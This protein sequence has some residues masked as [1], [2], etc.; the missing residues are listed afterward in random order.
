[1]GGKPLFRQSIEIVATCM[2]IAA[3]VG[4]AF[5]GP[6]LACR[7]PYCE[8]IEYSKK[9]LVDKKKMRTRLV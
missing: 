5:F 8:Y 4:I 3:Q 6:R 9:Y 7:Y 2:F 1:M